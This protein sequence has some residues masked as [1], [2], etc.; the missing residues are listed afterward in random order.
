MGKTLCA[1][2]LIFEGIFGIVPGTCAPG[3]ESS[4]AIRVPKH[5]C[6]L[7]ANLPLP[8]PLCVFRMQTFFHHGGLCRL[9]FSA[10]QKNAYQVSHSGPTNWCLKNNAVIARP[11]RTLVVAI[12]RLEGKC[13]DNC[14]TERQNLAIFGR[15]R[16][17]V[18]LNRGIATP[19]KRTGSQ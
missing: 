13:I 3:K 15:N 6:A 7:P 14:P 9:Q 8:A 10:E 18:P 17:L 4:F 2:C 12:P 5:G 11:V 1:L 19:L 16:Y